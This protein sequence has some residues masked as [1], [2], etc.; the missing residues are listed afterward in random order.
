MITKTKTKRPFHSR[1]KCR[2]CSD[3]IDKIDYKD[4]NLLERFISERGK[5]TPSRNSG[6][7]AR[8][9]RRLS[10]AIKKARFIALVP[11]VKS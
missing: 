9:Q 7:C 8:H 11:F 10:E 4:V 1:R 5:I 3:K 6:N 2:F